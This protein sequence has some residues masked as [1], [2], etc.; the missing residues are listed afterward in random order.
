MKNEIV[1]SCVLVCNLLY[2]PDAVRSR[3]QLQ[4]GGRMGGSVGWAQNPLRFDKRRWGCWS[5]SGLVLT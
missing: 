3:A 1:S 2:A 4:R 5:G